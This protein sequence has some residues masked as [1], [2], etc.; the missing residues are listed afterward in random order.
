MGAKRATLAAVAAH[1]GVSTSTASLAFSGSGPVAQITRDRVL[2]AAA[3]LGYTGPDP[4]ARSLRQGRSDVIAVVTEDRVL[5]AFRD[6]VALAFLDGLGQAIAPSGRALL[7]IPDAGAG[8]PVVHSAAVDAMV[9]LACS[10]N[11]AG[12]AQT[13]QS[14]DVPVVSIG[15]VDLP[16]VLQISLDDGP[17]SLVLARH[18]RELGHCRVAT[19]TLP[20]SELRER[21]PLSPGLDVVSQ[22]ALARLQAARGVFPD[23][24]G[25][26]AA[27][28]LVEEG[29]LAGRALLSSPGP[30]GE[31]VALPTA[32]RPTAVIAQSD[33][34]AVGVIRAAEELGISVPEQLSV[35]G[36]DGVRI[37]TLISHDLTTMVQP[38]IEQGEAAGRAA[39]A[40]I[41][42]EPAQP[43]SFIS[44][45][46][47]GATT[48]QPQG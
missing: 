39:V 28:S 36:F 12:A 26:V 14:R 10:P 31:P 43:L 44:V 45:F 46:H 24:S 37:D 35:V 2:A 38:A 41:E 1:A 3:E 27:G 40:L 17:A 8:K 42:G 29:W 11:L 18:L 6:P 23:L 22:P 4:R 48:A 25:W 7:L 33:L 9:L 20:L 21:G 16:G 30:N 47:R 5:D 15:G 13:A 32:Q 34:L 19:V